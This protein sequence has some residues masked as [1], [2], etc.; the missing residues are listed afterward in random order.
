MALADGKTITVRGESLGG[1]RVRLVAINHTPVSISGDV[2]TLFIAHA[3]AC[4]VLAALTTL[5]SDAGINIATL[6]TYRDAPGG[7]A[8]TCITT[9]GATPPQVLAALKALPSVE[10]ATDVI[11]PGTTP[12]P[13]AHT[14]SDAPHALPKKI[15]AFEAATTMHG[16]ERLCEKEGL[17]LAHYARERELLLGSP[18]ATLDDLDARMDAVQEAMMHAAHATLTHPK[19]SLGGLLDGQA[20]SVYAT[21]NTATMAPM[22]DVMTTAAAYAMST[23]EESASMGVIVAAPTAGSAGVVPGVL[24]AL[25]ERL[26]SNQQALHDA[27]WTAACIGAVLSANATVSGAEGGCQAEVGVAAAMAAAAATTYFTKDNALASNAAALALSNL[28]GLVCDPAGGLVEYP[29]QNRNVIGVA[30]ALTACQLSLAGVKSVV[31][32]DEVGATMLAV[33][34]ALPEALRETAQGGLATCPSAQK[35]VKNACSRCHGCA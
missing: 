8:F 7:R 12:A 24:L 11:I 6:S 2:P 30:S 9:D 25:K 21:L 27:L 34:H 4:G 35:A 10:F 31:P 29:C 13:T 1:A 23:L 16:I 15:H 19:R 22:G 28:L 20:A 17:T 14:A 18:G 3:D 26:G 5:V 33:G 32:L